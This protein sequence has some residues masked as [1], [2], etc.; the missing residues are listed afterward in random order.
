MARPSA[1]QKYAYLSRLSTTKLME[2]LANVPVPAKTP[3]DEAYLDALVEVILEREQKE[4]TGLL[5]DI[6]QAWAEFQQYYNTPEGTGLSLYPMDNASADV[7]ARAP[8]QAQSPASRTVRHRSLRRILLVAALAVCIVTLLL[9]PALGYENIFQMITS[10]TSESF[11]LEMED[12]LHSF[13]N[14]RTSPSDI[15]YNDLQSALDDYGIDIAVVPKWIPDGFRLD[16]VITNELQDPDRIE[17]RGYYTSEDED[18]VFSI[19]YNQYIG[20]LTSYEKSDIPIEEYVS[21]GITHYMFENVGNLVVVWGQQNIECS[22]SGDLSVAEAKKM[23]DSI[24]S[25]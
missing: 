3:E 2:L 18:R 20:S 5:P 13:D 4:P 14:G 25:S 24:Y 7:P 15:T 19:F 10:W 11:T 9:P 23:V 16:N 17:I 1:N 22:I 8:S 12:N 6:D 21:G